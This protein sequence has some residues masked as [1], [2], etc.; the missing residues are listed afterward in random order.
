MTI[1]AKFAGTC[2]KCG[3]PIMVGEKIEW[4]KGRGAAHLEC[5][6]A[7]PAGQVDPNAIKISSGSGYGGQEYLAGQVLRHRTHGLI[8]VVSAGSRYI[9]ED[10]MSFGVGDDSG[11]LYWATCRPA[12]EVEAAPLL[13]KEAEVEA[14][15]VRASEL[16]TFCDD[17]RKRA[18]FPSGDNLPEGTMVPV[19]K[20]QDI[21]GGGSWFVI[22]TDLV[23]CV[24]NN[25]RDGDDW[26]RNNVRTGG[27][28]A[29]GWT[30]PRTDNL[31][32]TIE[33]LTGQS[34]AA[35]R[36]AEKAEED[37]KAKADADFS[38][39]WTMETTTERRELWNRSVQG[40]KFYPEDLRKLEA[41]LG[42]TAHNLKTAVRKH[43]LPPWKA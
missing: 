43:N 10:G 26:S 38:A 7:K 4:E 18:N 21:W 8:Y 27:A 30:L 24:V 14:A 37:A 32:Q 29:M 15:K 11:Y 31:V 5:P 41:K 13:A 3:K 34:V 39:E 1:T 20:G 40:K 6:V 36:V 23:W 28:G 42:F 25:G 22:G 16:R 19:G 12:T 9:R 2:R 33:R 35:I 17:F